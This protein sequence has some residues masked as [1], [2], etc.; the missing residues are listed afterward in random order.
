VA[1]RYIRVEFMIREELLVATL[2]PEWLAPETEL[3]LLIE[4]DLEESGVKSRFETMKIGTPSDIPLLKQRRLL[5]LD[6]EMLKRVPS[7]LP[8]REDYFYF[9]VE[10]DGPYWANVLRDR[11]LA[12]AGGLDPA[13][14][15]ALFIVLKPAPAAKGAS[16]V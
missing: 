7:G 12:I 5:G 3:Y 10:K 15:F 11:I 6:L 2:A 1:S 16:R 13:L 8:A 4:S 9:A 14:K